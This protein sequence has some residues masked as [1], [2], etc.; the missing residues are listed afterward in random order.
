M[1]ALT[2]ECISVDVGKDMSVLYRHGDNA[3]HV[4]SPRLCAEHGEAE[5]EAEGVA[6]GRGEPQRE[7][8]LPLPRGHPPLEP[9]QAPEGQALQVGHRRGP[10]PSREGRHPNRR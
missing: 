3:S 4:S 8:Q 5:G 1:Y 2:W 10:G 7:E 9:D 6:P